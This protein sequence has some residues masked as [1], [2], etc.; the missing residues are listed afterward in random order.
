MKYAIVLNGDLN[1]PHL[2]IYT[3]ILEDKGIPYDVISWDRGDNFEKSEFTY[4]KL[5]AYKESEYKRLWS[6]V[7][8]AMFIKRLVRKY[9]YDKLIVISP[10]VA[11]FIPF[12]LRR[13]YRK[14]YVFDYRDLSIEQ[15]K[16]FKPLMKMVLNNSSINVISSPGFKKYLPQ[17]YDYILSHNFNIDL[18]NHALENNSQP[19]P[20][21][22]I[23]VLTIGGIR[24]DANYN[25][26]DALGN[27]DG[28]ELDF[29]GKGGAA[30]ILEEYVK[31]KKFVNIFFKG[32][33]DKK[34]E[35]DIIQKHTFI[36]IFY[37]Q[38]PS[39][40]SAL[41]N[42]FYNS[43]INRRPM[44]VTKGGEQGNYVEKYKV[45]LAVESCEGLAE[46][47]FAYKKQLDFDEYERNCNQ[48]LKVFCEDYNEF[49][50][51]IDKFI[52]S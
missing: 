32:R 24:F 11:L 5:S 9:K 34:D 25:V 23:K 42:R 40:I 33:Y 6:Y 19:L 37:P 35:N 50:A 21:G 44:I 8:F 10:Q 38:K 7:Q 49:A 29:V 51:S 14:K 48:L 31:D 13:K 26:I 45:G 2:K 4:S 28:I 36:N 12:F 47:L 15:K 41:S 46:K 27:V 20:Q 43:L 22:D 39:H 3:N 17:G 52:E 18:V 1:A 16:F 30:P